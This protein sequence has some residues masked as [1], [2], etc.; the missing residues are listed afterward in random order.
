M[1]ARIARLEATPEGSRELSNEV[2]RAR[3]WEFKRGRPN[4]GT[5]RDEGPTPATT[6]VERFCWR[7]AALKGERLMSRIMLTSAAA[8]D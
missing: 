6:P 8:L 4:P 1:E 7:H 5:E 3:G 2:L